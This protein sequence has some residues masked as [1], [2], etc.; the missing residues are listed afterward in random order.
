MLCNFVHFFS[1]FNFVDFGE[2][3]TWWSVYFASVP[4]ILAASVGPQATIFAP[5][6]VL[7]LISPV[8]ITFLLLKLSG[9]PLLE[10]KHNK[11][12]EG[13]KEYAEYVRVTPLLLPNPLLA[14]GDKSA[15]TK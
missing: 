4:A 15:K 7:A 14:L 1:C 12:Y 3:L 5:A 11:E 9:I 2:L 8:F 10:K 13:N 6:P